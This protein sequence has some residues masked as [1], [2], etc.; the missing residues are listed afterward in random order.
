MVFYPESTDTHYVEKI[1]KQFLLSGLS[2]IVLFA[3]GEK[4]DIEKEKAASRQ[5]AQDVVMESGGEFDPI[6]DPNAK[7]GGT[8]T[9]WG[10]S[11]PKSLNMWL[12]YNSFSK[13]I[14]E[15][16]FEPLA[17][18][19]STEN[20]PVG[21]LAE[22]WEISDDKMTY[23][24]KINDQA[25]WS[26]GKPITAEDVQ[27]YYDVI[28]DP[29]NLT[30][31]FRVDL[32]RFERPE[33][34]DEKTIRFSAVKHHW[35]NFWTACGMVALPRH[36]W[37]NVDFNEQ[38][39]EFPVVCGAYTLKEVKKNRF[40]ELERRNDWWGR[41][42]KY[43]Q[44]KYNFQT[45]KY[46]FMEDRNKALE[47]FKTQVFDAYAVYTS[48]IWMTKT[49]FD[50]VKK[51]WVVRQN[52]YNKEP[53]GY[54]GMAINL[55][56][57]KFRDVR[58]RR[59]LCY[60]LNRKLMNEKLM[61]NQYFLLN[62]FYPDLYPDNIN[63]DVPV[64]PYDPD[65]ARALLKEA[66]WVV[67]DNGLLVKDGKP[68]DITFITFSVDHRH[69]NIYL[70]D[71]KQVGFVPKIEQL[72]LSSLRKRLD[73]HD[74][75]MYW[76]AW[77]ASRLRDPEASWSSATAM[78]I[79]TNNIPGV[80]DSIVDSI[81][82]VQK[83]EFSLDKRIE[84]LKQLDKRLNEIVPYVLLWQSDKHRMLYWNKFGTPEY[85]FD[86]F[87]NEDIIPIYWWYDAG[88]DKA[89][90]EA[91]KNDASLESPGGDIHYAE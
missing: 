89:L 38:N 44:Y 91:V 69:L 78:D 14:T 33:V 59:A 71:L 4:R 50:A 11:F 29:K 36:I 56:R 25:T 18:L 84:L 67:D 47:A 53:K 8:Y 65:K 87:N 57:D 37:K 3:C 35:S 73:K 30:S 88:K 85:V 74:F 7:P 10:S 61:Y 68:F 75:D 82:E 46:K 34:I 64:T 13:Q 58:V 1:M 83:T 77:G 5:A 24:F 39:F 86:K 48:S 40:I 15:L 23:T 49:N 60:L 80:R 66:G 12:D 51:G 76:I 32:K 62:S 6:A 31:L 90:Q 28:M 79:A 45:I 9:T 54:Q 63:P 72:S 17:T 42:K 41:I 22:S 20:N 70:E 27:F 55:R 16:L 52:I 19:H 26:D 81:I 43:N 2:I 21:I